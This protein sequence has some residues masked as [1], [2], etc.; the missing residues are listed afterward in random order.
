MAHLL[1]NPGCVD[2]DL[3]CSSLYQVLFG[4]IGNGQKWLSRRNI[5]NQIQSNPGLLADGPPCISNLR[6]KGGNESRIREEYERWRC[7]ISAVRRCDDEEF[8]RDIEVTYYVQGDTSGRTEPPI[9]I[10]LIESC[11]LL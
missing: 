2:F 4:Q 11:V 10:D 5:S 9:D 1:A 6:T 3:C 8:Y 7:P